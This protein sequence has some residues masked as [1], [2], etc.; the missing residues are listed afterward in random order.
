MKQRC[1]LES[2]PKFHNYGGRGITVCDAWR[3]SFVA[4]RDWA[5]TNGYGDDLSIDRIDVNGNYCPEN[6]QW[7]TRSR[8]ARNTRNSLFYSAWGET[9]QLSD[10]AEDDRCVVSYKTALKRLC[11]GMSIEDALTKP[12]KR[13]GGVP[14]L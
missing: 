5:I 13:S 9:R 11:A 10:W 1:Y 8:Q 2:F 7:A 4:F 3:E 6:C 14:S 12:S